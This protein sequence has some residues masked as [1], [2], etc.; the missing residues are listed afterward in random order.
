MARALRLGHRELHV[1]EQSA[2]TPFRD[3]P[4]GLD[5]GLGPGHADRVE[6]EL[7]RQ[8][9]DVVGGHARIVPA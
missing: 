2:C 8:P 5:V 4:L 3:V 6:T 1:R 9:A 7:C